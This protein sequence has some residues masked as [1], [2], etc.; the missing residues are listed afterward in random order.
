MNKYKTYVV[1]DIH[2][3]YLA[4]KNLLDQVSFDYDND[5]LI[6]LG[7][8]CDGWSQTPEAIELLL[9]IKNLV[10]VQGNHDEWAVQFLNSPMPKFNDYHYG[11]YTSW[12]H[13]KVSQ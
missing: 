3:A 13:Q 4:L 5:K 8:V 6:A 12:F 10:Y 9:S 11:S 2:G 1:G 7:D